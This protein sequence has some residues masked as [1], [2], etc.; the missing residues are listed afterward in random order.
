MTQ[1]LNI[2]GRLHT[3]FD[4]ITDKLQRDW[5]EERA[6]S[7][8]KHG[9]P[10]DKNQLLVC[11][12]DA[13]DCDTIKWPNPNKENLRSALFDAREMGLIPDEPYVELPDGKLF[14][15]DE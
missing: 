6:A 7:A 15:I 5:A 9:W 11:H 13:G 2:D 14:G 1:L 12:Y 4:A 8:R 10:D 3:P